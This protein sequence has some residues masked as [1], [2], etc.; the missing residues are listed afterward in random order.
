[1]DVYLFGMISP[2][3]VYVIDP[4]FEYP[5][6]NE[7]SEVKTVLPS[8]GGEATNSAFVLSKLGLITKLDGNW[9][10]PKNAE[11]VFGI[12]KPYNID[13]SRLTVKENFGTEEIV[14]TDKNSRTVF[15]NYAAFQ[16]GEKQWN[17]P[18]EEDIK[19]ASIIALDPYLKAESKM[20]AEYCVKHNKPYVTLDCRYD[21]Y[22]AQHAAAIVISH[23]LR[24]QHYPRMD[25]VLLFKKYQE[26]CKGLIIVTFGSDE[27]WYGRKGEEIKKFKPFEIDPLDTTG[28]GDAFRGA[29]TYGLFQ[30]WDDYKTVEFAS[31]LSALVCM[32]MPHA[33]N[34]PELGQVVD[35]IDTHKST[36]K[37]P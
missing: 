18:V 5:K 13:T 30:K 26:H 31:A 21:D 9:I 35:F 8:I 28:A 4:A 19:E 37:R 27:L 32:S 20:V 12:F 24:D 3:T 1:M 36:Q 6:A 17:A 10:N 25:N 15:G 22:M 14:I 33:L 34:A 2:S 16:S 11:K 7:Y 29:I 23:E